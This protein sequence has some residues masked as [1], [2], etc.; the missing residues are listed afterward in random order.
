MYAFSRV[1][2]LT[3]TMHSCGMDTPQKCPFR[4]GI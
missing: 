4:C 1:P 3:I 2:Q